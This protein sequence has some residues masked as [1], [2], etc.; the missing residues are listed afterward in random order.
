MTWSTTYCTVGVM[1]QVTLVIL[2]PE[3]LLVGH[4][5][6]DLLL[7]TASMTPAP[8]RVARPHPRR[9]RPTRPLAGPGQAS[10]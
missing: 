5:I 7:R 4:G 3:L 10:C 8:L 1:F 2:R 6:A 9:P